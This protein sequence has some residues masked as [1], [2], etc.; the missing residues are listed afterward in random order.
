MRNLNKQYSTLRE[1]RSLPDLTP[2]SRRCSPTRSKCQ[3][4]TWRMM[5]HMIEATFPFIALPVWQQNFAA[6]LLLFFYVLSNDKK[7]YKK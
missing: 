7:Q 5:S 4:A 6:C 1:Y 3:V 2:A